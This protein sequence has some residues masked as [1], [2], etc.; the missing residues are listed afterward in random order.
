MTSRGENDVG[1]GGNPPRESGGSYAMTV[2]VDRMN[3]TPRTMSANSPTDDPG[4]KD[5]MTPMQ[6]GWEEEELMAAVVRS[7]GCNGISVLS[8]RVMVMFRGV[9]HGT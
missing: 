3:G 9:V 7:S 8:S 5:W 4:G 6:V 2:Y 1:G